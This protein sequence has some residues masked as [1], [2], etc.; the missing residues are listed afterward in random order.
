MC[1]T[2]VCLRSLM[3]GTVVSTGLEVAQHEHKWTGY[4]T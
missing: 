2:D 1:E 3:G 4:I